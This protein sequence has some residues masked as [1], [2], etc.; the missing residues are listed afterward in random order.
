MISPSPYCRIIW[1]QIT[2]NVTGRRKMVSSSPKAG[3]ESYSSLSLV[4]S[5][6]SIRLC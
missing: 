3:I 2:P 4:P 6:C 1:P 5:G